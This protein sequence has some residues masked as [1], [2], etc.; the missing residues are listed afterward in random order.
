MTH[1]QHETLKLGPTALYRKLWL[2]AA[3]FRVRLIGYMALLIVAQ[4]VKLLIPYYT[5]KAID[6]MQ[7]T[8]GPDLG[9]AGWD[10]A[11]IFIICLV[12]WAFHGPGRTL[13]RYTA[14]RI[15]ERF[16]DSLY[17]K[18]VSL[19]LAW[20]ERHHSGET[21]QRVEKA[22]N[23]LFNFAQNQ[24]VYLQNAVSL[25]GP[26]VALFVLSMPTGLAAVAGYA[27]IGLVLVRFDVVMVR[28]NRA[29]NRAERRYSAALIDC[30]GNISTVLTL[31]L[32]RATRALLGRKLTE[33]FAP[34]RSAIVLNETKWCVIDILN[35]GLRCGLAALYVWLVWRHGG[36]IVLGSA[37]MVYQY[38]QQSG[39]VVGNMAGNYQDLIG[40]QTDV[41]DAEPLINAVADE[42]D[43]GVIPAGWH[44]IAIDHLTFAYV[45]P[46]GAAPTLHD[47]SLRLERGRRIAIVGES[48]SGKSTL[49]RVLAG[50]YPAGTV[51]ISIDG[52][53]HPLQTHLGS[54]AT[55]VPQDPEIFAGTIGHNITLGIDQP[56]GALREAC[57]LACF[58]PVADALPAG[59]DTDIAERGLNL[60]GGQKQRLALARGILAARDSSL[61]MLDEPTSSL[62]PETEA[63]VYDN[64]LG[65]FPDTTVISSV[66]RLHLLNRFDL[67]ILMSDGEIIAAGTTLELLAHEPRF[68][69]IWERYA[70]STQ[71]D[72]NGATIAA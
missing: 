17:A 21:I 44:E 54:I 34:L 30:L 41:A 45:G 47:V 66:H 33:V 71:T 48:G 50:L 8:G 32:E 56:A 14:M 72:Q 58:T 19:P 36:G 57:D 11:L 35:N 1:V 38:A 20:H 60:S 49:L 70:G 5:G 9:R 43:T 3:G 23:A 4:L 65:A 29:Q 68:Q 10:M 22:G 59:L 31:R 7:A 6:A 24:F 64:L 67:V 61:L 69:A 18:A 62:D 12:G 26:I 40:Y 2:Y 53:L 25:F 27:V 52:V 28:I 13:E 51:R 15:R 46:R 42:V 37:V 63:L 55:L 39:G 16:A